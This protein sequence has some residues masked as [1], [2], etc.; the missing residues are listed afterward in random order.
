MPF[1]PGLFLPTGPYRHLL[2][3]EQTLVMIGEPKHGMWRVQENGFVR[4]YLKN[5]TEGLM[6]GTGGPPLG[7]LRVR[8]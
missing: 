6:N 3:F 4:E 2:V 8:L 1:G 5:G 7:T